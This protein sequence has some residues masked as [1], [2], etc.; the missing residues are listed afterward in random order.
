M[1]ALH[2][3]AR[4]WEVEAQTLDRYA[5]E[6]GAAAARLHA[7]ELREAV[8]EAESELLDPQAAAAFSNFSKRRLRELTADGKLRNYGQR[9][10]PRYRRIDLPTKS[11][12]TDGFDAVAEARRLFQ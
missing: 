3:L 10:A 6:R 9:G 2:D 7:T 11:R 8:R 5:D 4:K 1:T 12:P